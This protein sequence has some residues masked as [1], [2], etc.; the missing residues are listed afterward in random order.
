MIYLSPDF[1][2]AIYSVWNLKVVIWC[3]PRM[4]PFDWITNESSTYCMRWLK[5]KFEPIMCSRTFLG[6]WA[7]FILPVQKWAFKL[8]NKN[9]LKGK[10]PSNFKD[11]WMSLIGPR[12]CLTNPLS[13]HLPLKG[14]LLAAQRVNFLLSIAV[15]QFWRVRTRLT[16]GEPRIRSFLPV[17]WVF[18]PINISFCP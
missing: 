7:L 13:Q 12:V 18:T 1:E 4:G 15:T 11:T 6:N 5:A 3:H 17:G 2:G 14:D 9:P 8:R 16:T 10:F